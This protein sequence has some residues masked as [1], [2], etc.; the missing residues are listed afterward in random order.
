[1]KPQLLAKIACLWPLV[2]SNIYTVVDDRGALPFRNTQ[3]LDP[4][5]QTPRHGNITVHT[6]IHQPE[7]Q[8]PV[9]LAAADIHAAVKGSHYRAVRQPT[10]CCAVDV[11]PQQVRLNE[12]DSFRLYRSLQATKIAPVERPLRVGEICSDAT[13]LQRTTYPS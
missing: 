6:S 9:P 3:T 11:R 2:A 8:R 10:R 7:L 1:W 4:S 5:S 13:R 12:I